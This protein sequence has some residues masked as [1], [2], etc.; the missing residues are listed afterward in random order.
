MGGEISS[1]LGNQRRSLELLD[2]RAIVDASFLQMY[3]NVTRY[4]LHPRNG[5]EE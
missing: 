2:M 3:E 5:P 4:D 1:Y